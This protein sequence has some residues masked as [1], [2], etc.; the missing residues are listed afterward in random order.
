ME[1]VFFSLQS[2]QKIRFNTDYGVFHGIWIDGKIFVIDLGIRNHF[3][4]LFGSGE[5]PRLWNL[6][7]RINPYY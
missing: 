2:P 3:E 1:T 5:E 4:K 6:V 7:A